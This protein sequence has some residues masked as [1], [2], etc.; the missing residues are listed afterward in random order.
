MASKLE[1]HQI[2]DLVNSLSEA[3]V[4]NLETP[5][6]HFLEPVAKSLART[7][8]GSEVSLHVLCCNE[9]FLVT[10]LAPQGSVREISQVADAIRSAL[11]QALTRQG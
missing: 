8:A 9:Y 7:R 10:G 6:S 4:L 5:V 3:K 2:Q 11:D 1:H